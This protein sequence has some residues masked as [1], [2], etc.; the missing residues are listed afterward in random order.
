MLSVITFLLQGLLPGYLSNLSFEEVDKK[1]IQLTSV[2]PD[3]K[4][5]VK[6]IEDAVK[7]SFHLKQL[8]SAIEKIKDYPEAF[9]D[10]FFLLIQP[11]VQSNKVDKYL[12]ELKKSF[13]SFSEELNIQLKVKKLKAEEK[14]FLFA[15][16][17]DDIEKH[18]KHSVL[19]YLFYAPLCE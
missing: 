4:M 2:H 19:I 14:G 18:S 12:D 9:R 1:E 15:H 6:K 10:V 17:I 5:D 16:L 8:P 3:E 13:L 7:S 11:L